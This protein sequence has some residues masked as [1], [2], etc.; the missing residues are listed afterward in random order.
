MLQLR[1]LF[2]LLP[3]ATIATAAAPGPLMLRRF[4]LE[5]LLGNLVLRSFQ[6]LNF[7]I[8]E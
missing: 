8:C 1:A 4:H 5:C 3:M 6:A 2:P 7:H